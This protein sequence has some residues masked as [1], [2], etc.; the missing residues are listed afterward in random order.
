MMSHVALTVLFEHLPQVAELALFGNGLVRELLGFD[1]P[2]CS[3]R[4]R[5]HVL[6][7]LPLNRLLRNL[8]PRAGGNSLGPPEPTLLALEGAALRFPPHELNIVI[9]VLG[10]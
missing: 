6:E 2:I 4:H 10:T 5:D 1:L 9:R 3:S 8:Q 7:L